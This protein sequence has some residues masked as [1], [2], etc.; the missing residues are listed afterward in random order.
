MPE[1]HG[2]NDSVKGRNESKCPSE[3]YALVQAQVFGLVPKLQNEFPWF[4]SGGGPLGNSNGAFAFA[5]EAL[6]LAES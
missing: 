6:K 3:R 5:L 2:G 1:L 4:V